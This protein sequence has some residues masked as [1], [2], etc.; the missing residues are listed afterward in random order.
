MGLKIPNVRVVMVN[1]GSVH[2]LYNLEVR[3][4]RAGVGLINCI[5]RIFHI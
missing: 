1:G 3:I 2:E 5:I 4:L